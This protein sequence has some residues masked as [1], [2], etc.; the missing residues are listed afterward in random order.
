[1]AK[2]EKIPVEELDKISGT[3]ANGRL[4]K[5]D[6]ISYLGKRDT[7]V[8]SSVTFSQPTQQN[9]GEGKKSVTT[10]GNVDIVEMDRMRKLIADHM[11]M[12]KQTS[13]HVTSLSKQM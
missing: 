10:S 11:V 1:M 13:P 8:L 6:I 2:E 4:T 7:N 3:G 12:S 5:Y 9:Q